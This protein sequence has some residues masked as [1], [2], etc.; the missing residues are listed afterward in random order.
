MA[1]RKYDFRILI[2]T[3]KG[4]LFSYY[5]SSIANEENDTNL[6]LSSSEFWTNNE[7]MYWIRLLG[8]R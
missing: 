5:S 3:K 8:K 2:E 1:H 7:R 6:I 4:K